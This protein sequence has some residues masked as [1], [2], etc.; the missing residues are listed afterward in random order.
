MS[1]QSVLTPE[2]QE[3]SI[4]IEDR[5][6]I[7][8]LQ[9]ELINIEQEKLQ[10]KQTNMTLRAALM[11]FQEKDKQ[12]SE[13]IDQLASRLT[14]LEGKENSHVEETTHREERPSPSV[15]GDD[16]MALATSEG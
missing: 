3:T 13:M 9:Q 14:E 5:F 6:L 10:L 16:D 11:Q 7:Q 1:D 12:R 15:S 4:Q 2:D 8:S